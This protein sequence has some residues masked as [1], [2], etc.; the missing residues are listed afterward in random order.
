[1]AASKDDIPPV[2][3]PPGATSVPPIE[4][5]PAA[6]TAPEAP[7]APTGY[8]QPGYAPSYAPQAAGPAQGLSIASM[9]LGIAGLLLALVGLGF[10]V[11]VAAVITGHLGQK[12]QPWAKPFWLTGIITGYV[13]LAISVVTLVIIIAFVIFAASATYDYYG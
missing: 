1:M 2:P 4:P 13:G 7:T 9:I 3:I 5:A 8:G 6:P 11:S 10:L 12:R